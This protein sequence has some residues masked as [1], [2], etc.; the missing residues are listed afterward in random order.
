MVKTQRETVE[1]DLERMEDGATFVLA[2]IVGGMSGI[3]AAGAFFVEGVALVVFAAFAAVLAVFALVTA[4]G[5]NAARAV[6]RWLR[7]AEQDAEEAQR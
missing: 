4:V 7:A 5:A 6:I 2:V 1:Q 3:V